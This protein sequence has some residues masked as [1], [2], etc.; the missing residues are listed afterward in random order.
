MAVLQ[1]C[2]SQEKLS[3]YALGK[4]SDEESTSIS[5]HLDACND[6]ISRIDNVDESVDSLVHKLKNPVPDDE[7]INEPECQQAVADSHRIFHEGKIELGFLRD[8]K[9]LHE[10][11]RGGMGTVYY[12]LHTHL[13][14]D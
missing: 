6:C 4:L 10:L 12:A 3:D 5:D 1:L 11:G 14:G 2:P 13:K 7:F 8:Y 9:L